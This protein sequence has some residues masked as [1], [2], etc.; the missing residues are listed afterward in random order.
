MGWLSGL[1]RIGG[2]IAAPFTGGASIPISQAAAGMMDQVGKGAGAAASSAAQGRGSKAEMMMDLQDKLEN[3]L[4][5]REM[6]KREAQSDAY[7]KTQQAART[8][9]WKP[10][11]RPAGVPNI[12]FTSGPGDMGRASAATLYGQAMNRLQAPDLQNMS[13]MPEYKPLMDPAKMR[14]DF[15]KSLSPGFWERLAGIGAFV[16]PIASEWVK[17]RQGSSVTIPTTDTMKLPG[18]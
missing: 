6:E 7:R 14:S 17:G 16:A 4:L 11:M 13:G 5:A 9:Q 12:S 1:T 15:Q 10:A 2:A 3:Q 8:M 18:R